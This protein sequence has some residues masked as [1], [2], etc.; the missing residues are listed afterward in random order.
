MT[1]V[2]ENDRIRVVLTDEQSTAFDDS[3]E[4]I[5]SHAMRVLGNQSEARILKSEGH[6]ED[7]VKDAALRELTYEYL[8]GH[9]RY[10]LTETI[11][12]FNGGHRMS[13]GMA[14]DVDAAKHY[15]QHRIIEDPE[16]ATAIGRRA[17]NIE[18]NSEIKYRGRF[19]NNTWDIQI[20]GEMPEQ[21]GMCRYNA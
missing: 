12:R 1:A 6:Q 5:L 7:E 14:A 9:H 18:L 8:S 10:D 21:I 11:M 20:I 2:Y 16:Q 17:L 15:A 3:R 4:K 13:K 19:A